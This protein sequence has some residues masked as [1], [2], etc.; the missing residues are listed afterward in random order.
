MG[1]SKL[2]KGIRPDT[3]EG[4]IVSDADMCDAIGSTGILRNYAYTLKRDHTF[5][6]KNIWP[7]E[8]LSAEV[9]KTK[10]KDTAVC[11]FFEKLLKLKNLMLTKEGQQE[12][13]YRNEIMVE[14]L[15]HFFKEVN[16][17]DWE[18]YLENYIKKY[19]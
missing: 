19:N 18:N 12:A 2:L 4:Q 9:Y 15:R 6:D 1:Y 11:H 5:F 16:A 8:E 3:I 10:T 14:F 7:C 17:T 13:V